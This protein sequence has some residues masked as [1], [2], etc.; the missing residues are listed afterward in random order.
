LVTATIRLSQYQSS[1]G[2]A[3][4]EALHKMMLYLHAHPDQGL[5]YTRMNAISPLE[6]HP[7]CPA[8]LPSTV[9]SVSAPALLFDFLLSQADGLGDPVIM[10]HEPTPPDEPYAYEDLATMQVPRVASVH[11]TDVP[12]QS[13]ASV[14]PVTVLTPPPIEGEMD[15][16]HGSVFETIGFTGLVLIGL[17]TGFSET[18]YHGLQHS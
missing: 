16:N 5:T 9:A 18:S 7:E 1:P 11:T 3:H 8:P 17:G 12:V 2:Q 6:S 14:S 4:F 10:T 13:C 15:A